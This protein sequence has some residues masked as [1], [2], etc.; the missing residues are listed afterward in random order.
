M[1]M[2]GPY[3][4]DVDIGVDVHVGDGVDIDVH[5]HSDVEIDF[6]VHVDDDVPCLSLSHYSTRGPWAV[7]A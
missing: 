2:L 1:Y 5:V 4:I 3:R 6:D 7:G